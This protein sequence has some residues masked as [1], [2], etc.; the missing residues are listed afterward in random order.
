MMTLNLEV[1]LTRS[2]SLTSSELILKN[3]V[4]TVT[5]GQ[6]K[7][8]SEE[9]LVLDHLVF[10][11]IQLGPD[12]APLDSLMFQI[13][14]KQTNTLMYVRTIPLAAVFDFCRQ[15]NGPFQNWVPLYAPGDPSNQRFDPRIPADEHDPQIYLGLKFNPLG[16]GLHSSPK[17]HQSAKG[18][19]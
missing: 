12:R 7:R 10:E 18:K 1:S 4:V 19:T 15:V 16:P 14:N 11:N 6:H 8:Q 3:L 13:Q 2:R 9:T 5:C 17:T